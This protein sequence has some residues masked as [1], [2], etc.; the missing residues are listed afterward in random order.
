MILVAV[1]MAMANKLGCHIADKDK[2]S[3]AYIFSFVKGKF[4][5][6]LMIELNCRMVFA[7][8]R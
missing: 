5:S 1:A 3:T 7:L 2:W 6:H 8:S 4:V